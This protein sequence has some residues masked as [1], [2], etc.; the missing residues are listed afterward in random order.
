MPLDGAKTYFAQNL[1]LDGHFDKRTVFHDQA[2]RLTSVEVGFGGVWALCAPQLLFFPDKNCDDVPDGKPIVVLDG[3]DAGPVR[4]NIVNGLRW[5][6]DGWL[7]G[8]HGIQ[9]TS[10]VGAPRRSPAILR[11]VERE[12]GGGG[13]ADAD[14]AAG[15]GSRPGGVRGEPSALTSVLTSAAITHGTILRLFPQES[16]ELTWQNAR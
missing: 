14:V 11:L 13:G 5:G 3:F 4:H 12:T 2:Q 6:P 9:A 15:A 7:Y 1:K 10:H 16:P 8:R